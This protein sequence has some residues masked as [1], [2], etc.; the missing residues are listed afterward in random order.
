VRS[1][2]VPPATAA[3]QLDNAPSQL[4]DAKGQLSDAKGQ[5]SDAKGQ[6]SDAKGQL[7]TLANK[8]TR[9]KTTRSRNTS[10]NPSPNSTPSR[11][12]GTK[13]KATSLTRA[14]PHPTPKTP[15][16]PPPDQEA[17]LLRQMVWKPY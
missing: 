13:L 5:L 10:K 6:L 4:S 16:G 12:L 17:A 7:S 8:H 2:T 9:A 1:L 15:V 11:L 14:H 3:G